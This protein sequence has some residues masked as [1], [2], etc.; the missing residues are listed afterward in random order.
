MFQPM[1]ITVLFALGA[2][3]VI[4]L[5]LM[6]VL[7][8]YAFRR[9][10]VGEDHLADAQDQCR[11][12]ARLWAARFGFPVA[13]A[14]AAALRLRGIAWGRSIP[15]RGVH[16]EAGRG[17]DPGDDVP[18]ARH[19]DHRV[20][21]R[22]PDHRDGAEAVPGSRQGG[23]P[24]RAAGDRDRPDGHR[25]ERRVRHAEARLRVAVAGA[26]RTNWSRP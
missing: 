20:A 2:S 11:P 14:A 26:P 6:P 9:K 10:A 23:V 25:P 16:P 7:G 18:G 3:L 1:A 12:T 4:A 22:Q 21:A 5:T 15:G 17:L 8:W 24:H 13:T 19:L